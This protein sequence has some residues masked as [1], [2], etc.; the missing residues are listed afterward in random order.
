MSSD[1]SDVSGRDPG[2][3]AAPSAADGPAAGADAVE[4]VALDPRLDKLI[5]RTLEAHYSDIVAAPLPDAILVLLA[6]LE[7]KEKG[8]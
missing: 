5:G 2:K 8:K 6:Q 3:G 1:V 4:E 7:A